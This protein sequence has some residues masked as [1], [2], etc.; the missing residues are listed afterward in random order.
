[1][2]SSY[3]SHVKKHFAVEPILQTRSFETPESLRRHLQRCHAEEGIGGA[4]LIGKH[5]FPAFHANVPKR[6]GATD[7]GFPR[8]YEDL[9]AE[10]SDTDGDGV[11]D[12][13]RA[14]HNYGAE[15]WTAWIRRHPGIEGE[16]RFAAYFRKVIDY[17]EGRLYY[18]ANQLLMVGN[19]RVDGVG[20]RNANCGREMLDHLLRP[21]DYAEIGGHGYADGIH[22]SGPH[23]VV[24]IPD[25]LNLYPGS[26]AMESMSCWLADIRTPGLTPAEAYV[27]GRGNTQCGIGNA[28]KELWNDHVSRLLY[29]AAQWVRKCPNLTAMYTWRSDMRGTQQWDYY[30]GGDVLLG[31]PF[32]SLSHDFAARSQAVKGRVFL[33]ASGP[34]SG[35][36]VE[37][38]RDGQS[39]GRF[40]TKPDGSYKLECLPVGTYK[41]RLHLNACEQLVQQATVGAVPDSAIQLD[42]RVDRT[43]RVSGQVRKAKGGLGRRGW[44]EMAER[45]EDKLFRSSDM[46]ASRTDDQGRFEIIGLR[47]G[48]FWIRGCCNGASASAPTKVEISEGEQRPGTILQVGK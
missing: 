37:A 5:P 14:Q 20:L 3:A 22:T 33:A 41:V 42:F 17:Y 2:I 36:Y 4:V 35:F 30:N 13:A 23:G 6:F 43:W 34:A 27:F 18:P 11:L 47:E 12:T 25:A 29:G 16:K 39:F 26:L 19:E 1:M 46:I 40:L 24:S 44:V 48:T 7:G 9:D 8:Y 15:I 21:S 31:N 38:A 10:F 28:R 32:V 45:P